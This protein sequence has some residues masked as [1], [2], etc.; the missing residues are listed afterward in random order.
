MSATPRSRFLVA[1]WLFASAV[2]VVLAALA[3]RGMR[4]TDRSAVQRAA[5]A[6]VTP[7]PSP[8]PIGEPI[9]GGPTAWAA[10]YGRTLSQADGYPGPGSPWPPSSTVEPAPTASP[11]PDI[12]G[13]LPP[14]AE[15]DSI[16]PWRDEDALVAVYRLDGRKAI[17]VVTADGGRL[18]WDSRAEASLPQQAAKAHF[19]RSNDTEQ[20]VGGHLPMVLDDVGALLQ[21]SHGADG[22]VRRRLFRLEEGDVA[23]YTSQEILAINNGVEGVPHTAVGIQHGDDAGPGHDAL[24]VFG[25]GDVPPAVGRF[26]EPLEVLDV[27]GDGAEE[28]VQADGKGGRTVRRAG[29]G[30]ASAQPLRAPGDDASTAPTPAVPAAGGAMPAL[31]AGLCVERDKGIACWPKEGGAPQVVWSPGDDG[32]R[33][34]ALADDYNDPAAAPH[35]FVSAGDG[36]WLVMAQVKGANGAPDVRS[37]LMVLDRRSGERVTFDR[38]W[39]WSNDPWNTVHQ[40]SVDAALT[41]LA[42]VEL[43]VRADG[44]P[45]VPGDGVLYV[46]DL[47]RDGDRLRP[48]PRRAVATCPSAHL[49]D[50]ERAE[51]RGVVLS[52]DGRLAALMDGEGLWIVDAATGKRVG[53]VPHVNAPT[54][55]ADVRYNRPAAWSPD[56]RRLHVSVGRYEGSTDA[57]LDVATS[58]LFDVPDRPLWAGRSS[59]VFDGA[60]RAFSAHFRGYGSGSLSLLRLDAA[61]APTTTLGEGGHALVGEEAWRSPLLSFGPMLFNPFDPVVVGGVGNGGEL[62]FGLQRAVGLAA[63]T[64]VYSMPL[65]DHPS[66]VRRLL[67]L[68]AL[69]VEDDTE[70]RTAGTIAWTPDGDG[71]LYWQSDGVRRTVHLGVLGA[72]PRLYDLSAPMAG[73]RGAMWDR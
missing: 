6:S 9:S 50:S 57:V 48:G 20:V 21:L 11:T 26:A 56:G 8:M 43:G 23:G 10:L 32:W 58:D 17:A 18:L 68:P 39:G 62:R 22:V 63:A 19:A 40:W 2:L 4:A 49:S 54:R 34:D 7:A 36:R 55:E 29:D 14:G 47:G 66:D 33:L 31:P 52:P 71:F 16:G 28:I 72:S 12:R 1:A 67:A 15:V 38:A 69:P 42:W 37:R 13:A 73:V 3:W 59:V 53:G 45:A 41:R 44:R 5:S 27:D 60:G 61:T 51:C 24:I 46:V 25:D 65:G 70:A 35:A 30:Y 64:G